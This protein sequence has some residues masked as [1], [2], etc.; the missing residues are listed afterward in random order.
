[1]GICLT[2]FLPNLEYFGIPSEVVAES[3][4]YFTYMLIFSTV[5]GNFII[6]R[7]VL[8]V[9]GCFKPF[10]YIQGVNIITYFVALKFLVVWLDLQLK[11]IMISLIIYELG[12]NLL[13]FWYIL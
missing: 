5:S 12:N 13:V 11:G 3:K 6:L 2:L 7:S 4:I 10:M 9:F 8:N 1:M